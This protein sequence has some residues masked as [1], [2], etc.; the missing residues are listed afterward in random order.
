MIRN[1]IAKN[2][3]TFFWAQAKK[4]QPPKTVT[5]PDFAV[6]PIFFLQE[7]ADA[8]NDGQL[9]LGEF[10]ELVR[11]MR[12]LVA[13]NIVGAAGRKFRWTARTMRAKNV[14]IFAKIIEGKRNSTYNTFFFVAK[15]DGN[16]SNKP[17]LFFG[18]LTFPERKMIWEPFLWALE[19]VFVK[20]M[21][22]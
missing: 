8:D 21:N 20:I 16:F 10:I 1:F 2:Q 13:L 22:L 9:E 17:K 3:R 15:K 6:L 12:S 7:Y 5:C 11:Q 14:G 19:H 4:T 18:Q